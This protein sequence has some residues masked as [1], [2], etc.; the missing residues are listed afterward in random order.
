M[1]F[2]RLPIDGALLIEFDPIEDERGWLARSFDIDLFAEQGATVQW[3]QA[4]VS[5]TRSAGTLR[6]LHWQGEPDDAR[7]VR[8]VSGAIFDVIA[9]VRANSPSFLRHHCATLR[10]GDG[11]ALFVPTGVAHGFL[12]QADNVE[13]NYLH[14]GRYAR[15][16]ARV[17]RWNDPSFAINWPDA[18]L[19]IAERDRAAPDFVLRGVSE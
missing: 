12:T 11:R 5:M 15:D 4:N 18:P 19:L 1:R 2:E 3:V 17:L 9:D 13:V 6:G 8:C 7:L 14:S 10:A 16:Q